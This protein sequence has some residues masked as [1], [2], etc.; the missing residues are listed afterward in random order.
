MNKNKQKTYKHKHQWIYAQ[1]NGRS[2]TKPNPQ[3]C[4]NCSSKCAYNGMNVHNFRT[5]YKKYSVE[6]FQ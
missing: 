3:N 1:W 6:Q 4:H 5:Q 2:E